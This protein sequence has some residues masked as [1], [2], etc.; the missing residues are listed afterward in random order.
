M[1]VA[2][3]P[4]VCLLA[5]FTH[6]MGCGGEPGASEPESARTNG[7]TEEDGLVA[8]GGASDVA[9]ENTGGALFGHS[10]CTDPCAE[11]T[12]CGQI[13]LTLKGAGS[14]CQLTPT[15]NDLTRPPRKVRFNCTELPH[16]PNGYDFD[17]LG[18]ITLMG[19][20]CKAL[21]QG[22]PHHVALILSCPPS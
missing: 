3:L 8:S 14:S 16:G 19:D 5:T 22:G 13:C 18:H 11:Q 1:K 9:P 2:L 15:V 4:C 17:K 12:S 21:H 10:E 7:G 6:L 20:T